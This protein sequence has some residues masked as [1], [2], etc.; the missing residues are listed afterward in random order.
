METEI[1]QSPELANWDGGDPLAVGC[2]FGGAVDVSAAE[3]GTVY[4]FSKCAWWPDLM[5]DGSGTQIAEGALTLD[6]A[7]SGGHQG[8]ITY[9]H[10]TTT[11]AMTITGRYDGKSVATPRPM[12]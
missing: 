9:S 7:V 3:E 8:Q 5:L 4:T 12:P 2:G 1:A 10:N 6:L 11:D